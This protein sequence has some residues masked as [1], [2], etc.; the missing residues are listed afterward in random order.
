M[1]LMS[2]KDPGNY[3]ARSGMVSICLQYVAL[4]T[5]GCGHVE[6][7]YGIE[8]VNVR[9]FDHT[10]SKLRYE[11]WKLRISCI[12]CRIFTD[13]KFAKCGKIICC[14]YWASVIH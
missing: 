4:L 9:C 1:E 5:K 6:T 8:S 7:N 11:F 2:V 10:L 12:E 14:L 3:G 13:S